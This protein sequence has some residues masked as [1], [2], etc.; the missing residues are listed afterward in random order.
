MPTGLN[1]FQLRARTESEIEQIPC[2]ST[3]HTAADM[4]QSE[5]QPRGPN[6]ALGKLLGIALFL[7][8]RLAI[9][10]ESK[11]TTKTGLLFPRELECISHFVESRLLL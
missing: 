11:L 3:V 6:V 8:T 4:H 9:V 7:L 2:L 10:R 1:S 5:K